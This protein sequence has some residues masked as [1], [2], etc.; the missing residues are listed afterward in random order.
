MNDKIGNYFLSKAPMKTHLV[1]MSVALACT[2]A[3]AQS[4]AKD[5]STYIQLGYSSTQYNLDGI[6]GL[7]NANSLAITLGK[8]MSENYAL[9]GIYATGM[10]DSTSTSL[11][12]TVNLKLTSSYGLYVKPKMMISDAFELFAR[13]GY[14]NAKSSI[15]VPSF[16]SANTDNTGTS[17][18]YGLGASMR[19][20]ESI[21]GSL[22]WMQWYKKDGAD[23][24]GIGLSVG[25]KF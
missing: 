18:S 11:G 16:P 20:T 3:F 23:I 25:Y 19:L 14:F 5:D 6:S 24:K 4:K 7:S 12:T 21:Y 8:N 22:D 13:V 17:P 2:G 9:E 15:T 10:G 1:A